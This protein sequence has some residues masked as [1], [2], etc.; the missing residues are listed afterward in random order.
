METITQNFS[1]IEVAGL[2][3]FA[4]GIVVA[5]AIAKSIARAVS[6][7]RQNYSKQGG[8]RNYGNGGS[9]SYRKGQ[10]RRRNDGNYAI[11][12]LSVLALS[13]IMLAGVEP[14]GRQAN[15]SD[16]V[17]K[18]EVQSPKVVSAKTEINH[19]DEYFFATVK[20]PAVSTE[21]NTFYLTESKVYSLLS[22]AEERSRVL[23]ENNNKTVYLALIEKNGKQYYEIV[24]GTFKDYKES[25]TYRSE[26]QQ[27][28]HME[29]V[30]AEE[31]DEDSL[32]QTNLI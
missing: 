21:K 22:E 23:Q 4:L 9:R 5:V 12:F 13:L 29:L 18:G 1:Q 26:R 32:I 7:G 27:F 3:G 31:L 16:V 10:K 24:I 28:S 17:N 14:A 2:I 15:T 30:S 8:G 19:S 6:S 25:F 20:P 11:A